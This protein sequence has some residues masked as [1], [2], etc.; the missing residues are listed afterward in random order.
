MRERSTIQS[1]IEEGAT[2]RILHRGS[3]APHAIGA[4]QTILHWLGFDSQLRWEEFGADGFYGTA[5]GSAVAEFARRNGSRGRGIRVSASLATQILRRYDALEELKQLADDAAGSRI[6]AH[7]RRSS[8]NRIRVAA[9]QTL[10]NE[11]GYGIELEWARFGADGSYGPATA[12]AVR[13]F[14]EVQSLPGSGDRLTPAMANR[15]VAL[16]GPHYGDAWHDLGHKAA[17]APG[18]LTIRSVADREN[19]QSVEVSD[20][21]RRKRFRRFRLG[22]YTPGTQ[23]TRSFVESHA[24]ELQRR[25]VTRSEIKVLASV[26]ENEGH[27]DAVNTWDSAF[28]SFGMFQWTAGQRSDP[29]ELPALLARIKSEDRDLF[30]KYCGQH[31]LDVTDV[32]PPDWEASKH[33][34]LTGRFMLRGRPIR[35]AADKAQL[36]EAAW[37]FYFWRAGQD[38]SIQLMEVKHALGRLDWFYDTDHVTPGG[39]RV[40]ALVSSEYGVALLLDN[41]VNRPAYVQ[42]ILE[43]A[44]DNAGLPP[45]SVWGADEERTLIAAYLS[46]R[47]TF[48][49]VPMT[50]AVKRAQVTKKHLDQGI[51]SSERGSFR[52]AR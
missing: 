50:D 5:T 22:L 51:L 17:P 16:L 52:R 45:P 48:G 41:H 31:G 35:S 11:L 30:D 24:E 1:L 42:P 26:A 19:R 20:G 14:G 33:G 8:P 36:R 4:L 29:G 2:L 15:I 13:A 28:L 44:L 9:L 18:S 3:S 12:A 47:P 7:Y 46:L 21:F 6:E 43:E 40:A 38:P 32:L 10:L 27:L 23:R 37:A 49:R 34:P 39:H 25:G